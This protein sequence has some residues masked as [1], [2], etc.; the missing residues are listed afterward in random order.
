S[1]AH[2][3][4]LAFERRDLERFWS[5]YGRGPEGIFLKVGRRVRVRADPAFPFVRITTL[6]DNR[7]DRLYHGKALAYGVAAAPFARLFGLNGLLLFNVL[8]LWSVFYLGFRFLSLYLAPGAAFGW[9]LA[10]FGASVAPLYVVWLTSEIFNLA[11]VFFAYWL[12]LYKE[13]Q[14]APRPAPPR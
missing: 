14:P 12:W 3:G 11:L 2:D 13:A 5:L 7:T 4:D 6:P 10:F 9:S 8:L 1:V